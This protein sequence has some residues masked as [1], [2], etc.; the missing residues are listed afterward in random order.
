[1][2]TKKTDELAV[3][4]SPTGKATSIDDVG[5]R[6]PE[7]ADSTAPKTSR[8]ATEETEASQDGVV[9]S[10]SG[11]GDTTAP[12]PPQVALPTT[13]S[14]APV[15]NP[16]R[17]IGGDIHHRGYDIDQR[18]DGAAIVS[19]GGGFVFSLPRGAKMTGKEAVDNRIDSPVDSVDPDDRV[20]SDLET[21]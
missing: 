19:K 16:G 13:E 8:L 17:V 12:P 4:Q 11:R 20:L 5:P 7:D 3:K 14:G 15:T 1:M 2:V 6:T 21:V 10:E 18:S 9:Y